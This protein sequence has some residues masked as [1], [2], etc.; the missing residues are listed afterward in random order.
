M[1]AHP[2]GTAVSDLKKWL[3][4]P[5]ENLK[6]ALA[7]Y[8]HDESM[9]NLAIVEIETFAHVTYEKESEKS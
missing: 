7:K 3:D 4:V 6:A 9:L 8:I 2:V 5:E 1:K